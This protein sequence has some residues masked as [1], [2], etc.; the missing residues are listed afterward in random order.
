MHSY[1]VSCWNAAGTA[2]TVVVRAKSE[3][4]AARLAVAQLAAETG[5]SSWIPGWI[6]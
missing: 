1:R 6:L 5:D 3:T 4:S 2:R